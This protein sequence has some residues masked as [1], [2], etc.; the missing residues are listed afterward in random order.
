LDIPKNNLNDTLTLGGTFEIFEKLYGP[1]DVSAEISRCSLDMK[2]CEKLV[3]Y[4][5]KNICEKLKD[6]TV[7]YAKLAANIVPPVSCPVNSGNYTTATTKVDLK[8]F[9][10]FP[11][12]GFIY[13]NLMKLITTNPVSKSRKVAF[14]SMMEFKIV[15]VR[16][17]STM[18]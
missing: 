9:S 14:C 13:T 10:Y 5:F 15:K 17:D 18:N 16:M 11:L 2:T 12:D 8:E 4:N 7:I 6:P 1:I 3:N